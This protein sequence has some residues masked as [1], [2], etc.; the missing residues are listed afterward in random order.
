V[1]WCGLR[2]ARHTGIHRVGAAKAGLPHSIRDVTI[3]PI[4]IH[5][6][7]AMAPKAVKVPVPYGEC[8]RHG[9][10]RTISLCCVKDAERGSRITNRKRFVTV[11]TGEML[12][13][14]VA[15]Q[16]DDD[17]DAES[18]KSKMLVFLVDGL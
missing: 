7:L 9:P 11:P 4:H 5:H 1:L 16:N 12:R 17:A 13:V 3:S 8:R 18:V 14:E 10:L 6:A 2:I 15:V